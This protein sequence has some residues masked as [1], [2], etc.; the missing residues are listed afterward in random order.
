MNKFLFLLSFVFLFSSCEDTKKV[1]IASY[2]SDCIGLAPQKCLLFKENL[3]DKWSL[4]YDTIEGF[5]YEEGYVYKL[6]VTVKEIEDPPADGSSLRYSLVK[7]LSK[8]KVQTIAQNIPDKTPKIQD[9]VIHVEYQ[10]LSRGSFYQ[11]KINKNT[12]EKTAD[13]N[14]KNV[15]S[16]KCS[17]EDWNTIIALL[18]SINMEEI[19]T[20]EAPTAKRL[21]DG[22]PHAQ[23]SILSK[24]KTFTSNSFDHG[25][26]P[27]EIQQLVNTMLS[28]AESIE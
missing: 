6:E 22:A 23:V 9:N 27:K 7:V 11:I 17:K 4:F 24:D 25:H 18:N 8:E 19:S 28:L 2:Q 13:R 10:A 16:K 20:L 15:S 5:K 12:I 1:F 3:A 21:F 14:L 26:P